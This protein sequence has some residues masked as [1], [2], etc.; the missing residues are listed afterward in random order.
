MGVAQN[1]GPGLLGPMRR[2]GQNAGGWALGSLS[3]NPGSAVELQSDCGQGG[4]LWTGSLTLRQQVLQKPAG[5]PGAGA[6]GS[7][8]ETP[9]KVTDS[10]I[11]LPVTIPTSATYQLS[12]TLCKCLNPSVPQLQHL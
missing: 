7:G 4:D 12:V 8:G 2:S 11:N 1:S 3:S 10:G 6:Q 9:G 5:V